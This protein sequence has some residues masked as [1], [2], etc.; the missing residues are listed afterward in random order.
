MDAAGNHSALLKSGHEG[1]PTLI[2]GSHLDSVPNGGKYDG[3]LGVLAAL[4]SLRVIKEN[5]LKL[6]VNLEAIDFTDEEGTLV[7]LMGSAALAGSLDREVIEKPRGGR[8]NFLVGLKRAGLIEADLIK[9]RRDPHSLAGYLELHIEQGPKLSKNGIDIG[10]VTG[11]VGICSY[12]ISFL[13]QADH[14][15]TTPMQDD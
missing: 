2:L 6:A 9:A 8:E 10:I 11:I 1:A 4:E 3:A 14:A 12:R 13:G 5:H 15:G 7:G